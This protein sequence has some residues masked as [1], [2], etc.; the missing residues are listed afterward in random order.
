M[1]LRSVDQHVEMVSA[2]PER[3]KSALP[4]GEPGG[5]LDSDDSGRSCWTF[6]FQDFAGW[7]LF[8]LADAGF[9][10]N[11]FLH[12]RSV[13]MQTPSAEM[14]A[15]R[16]AWWRGLGGL[17]LILNTMVARPWAEVGVTTSRF[18]WS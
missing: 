17:G 14:A 9:C 8:G 6:R 2:D 11:C 13:M 10:H 4:L 3:S 18:F 7:T 16:I 1:N 15:Q 12:G 5:F